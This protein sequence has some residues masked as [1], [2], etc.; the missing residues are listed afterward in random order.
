[1][2]QTTVVSWSSDTSNEIEALNAVVPVELVVL[3]HGD[4]DA[5]VI[6]P[7]RW[8]NFLTVA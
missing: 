8:K 2:P 5:L 3:R 6:L 7:L 4:R 1:M